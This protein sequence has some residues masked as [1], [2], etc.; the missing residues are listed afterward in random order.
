MTKE[1]QQKLAELQECANRANILLDDIFP[2]IAKMAVQDYANLNEL[3]MLLAKH[4]KPT[5]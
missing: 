4:A 2:Q 3:A 1:E 5:H